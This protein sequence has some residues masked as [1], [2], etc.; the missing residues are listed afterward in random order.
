MTQ[1][2]REATSMKRSTV[3]DV[4]AAGLVPK[5]D[6]TTP[7]PRPAWSSRWIAVASGC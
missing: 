6:L 5:T 1:V 4:A 3:Q 2:G 7:M